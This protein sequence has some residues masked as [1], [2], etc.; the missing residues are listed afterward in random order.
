WA[1]SSAGLT[2]AQR[3]YLASWTPRTRSERAEAYEQAA[4]HPAAAPPAPGPR[5]SRPGRSAL[6]RL[7]LVRRGRVLG[8]LRQDALAARVALRRARDRRARLPLRQPDVRG[9]YGGAGRDL[10]ARGP[11][12]IAEPRDHRT[13]DPAGPADR[14]VVD[15]AGLG[16]EV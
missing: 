12:R 11:A 4:A 1:D 13:A 10:G 2:R 8:S 3:A 14:P 15:R 9:P 5:S 16:N 6:H 7:A